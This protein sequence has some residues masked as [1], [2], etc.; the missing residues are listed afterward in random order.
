MSIGAASRVFWRFRTGKVIVVTAGVLALLGIVF[1]FTLAK[2][3]I[4]VNEMQRKY[5]ARLSEVS[6]GMGGKVLPVYGLSFADR[7]ILYTLTETYMSLIDS[8]ELT[9]QVH[10]YVLYYDLLP[11]DFLQAPSSR[12]DFFLDCGCKRTGM[13]DL[14]TLEID[15]ATLRPC[16]SPVRKRITQ[17]QYQPSRSLERR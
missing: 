4:R 13:Y 16:A 7:T 2:F 9:E 5:E 6:A 10:G 11:P 14:L 3:V 12:I 8:L 17:D 15:P 1:L